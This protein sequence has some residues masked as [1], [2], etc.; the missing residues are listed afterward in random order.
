MYFLSVIVNDAQIVKLFKL[1]YIMFLMKSTW[2]KLRQHIQMFRELH[3][4]I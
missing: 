4:F 1:I 2:Y 3:I